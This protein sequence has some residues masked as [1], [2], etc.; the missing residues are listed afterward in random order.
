MRIHFIID[1]FTLLRVY[2][3]ARMRKHLMGDKTCLSES[4][5]RAASR[6]FTELAEFKS[7]PRHGDCEDFESLRSN[8]IYLLPLMT[9][10]FALLH[11]SDRKHRSILASRAYTLSGE[12]FRCP[13]YRMSGRGSRIPKSLLH[14]R[15]Q[16]RN[17]RCCP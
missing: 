4:L 15:R 7:P 16:L 1:I 14:G 10:T 3:G 13:T 2:K 9:L 8:F 12:V 6:A 17:D 5:H 11:L